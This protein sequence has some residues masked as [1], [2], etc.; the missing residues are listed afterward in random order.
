MYTRSVNEVAPAA[1]TALA[2]QDAAESGEAAEEEEAFSLGTALSEAV[3]TIPA[4][5]AGV[6]GMSLPQISFS[7]PTTLNARFSASHAS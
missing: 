7:L 2:E 6:P 4:N 1:Y 5:L 3:A